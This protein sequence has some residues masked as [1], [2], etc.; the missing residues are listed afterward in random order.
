MVL[1]HLHVHGACPYSCFMSMLEVHVHV[2]HYRCMCVYECTFV[3]VFVCI[4]AGMP[5]CPASDQSG[6][7]L[8]K[9]NDAGTGPVPDQ[10][11]A[12]WHFFWSGTRLEL[13][14]PECRCR[15]ADA[16]F[17]FLDADAQLWYKYY[18][19]KKMT[20]HFCLFLNL[21]LTKTFKFLPMTKTFF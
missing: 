17:S 3:C 11:K 7:G 13:L 19:L 15:S 2:A 1:V 18:N 10:A 21:T 9:T 4:N 12:V 20:Q 8:K 6:T 5:N 14:M 16:G